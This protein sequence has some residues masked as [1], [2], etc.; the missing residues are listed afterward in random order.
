MATTPTSRARI[1]AGSFGYR[2]AQGATG[3]VV[4][5]ADYYLSASS[6]RQ[7]GFRRHARQDT[8]RLAINA[9]DSS[10]YPIDFANSL[11][12]SGYGIWGLRAAG[13]IARG[14]GWFV[15]GRNLSDRRYAAT[16]GVVRDAGG[17]DTMQF[18]PG[19]GRAF[20]AGIDWKLN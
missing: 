11:G 19:D 13:E 2:R 9:E 18:L 7:D 1:E 10:G 8:A 5:D 16:T 20:Y 12:A 14:C 15:E 17:R 4:G 6:F 3:N